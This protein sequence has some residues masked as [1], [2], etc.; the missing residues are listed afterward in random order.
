MITKDQLLK[1]FTEFNEE[2]K[3]IFDL[4]F[5]DGLVNR[6]LKYS[7]SKDDGVLRS[8]L[9]GPN[10]ESIKAFCNDLRKF[11]Q[12]NDSLKIE[13]LQSFYQSQLVEENEKKMFG[14]E[15][16]QI[17][18]SLQQHSSL[19]INSKV[20]TNKEILEIF[21]YGKVSHRTDGTK[22]EYNRIQNT[23]IHLSFKDAFITVLQ[24]YLILISNLV[25]INSEVIKKLQ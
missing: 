19:A 21:L 25:Y 20:Y 6:K 4:S 22:E 18:K 11:I 2:A 1:K 14:K 24:S 9:K 5:K 16:S 13:K 15:M 23:P 7:W 3:E 17:D 12:G 8:E 10:D